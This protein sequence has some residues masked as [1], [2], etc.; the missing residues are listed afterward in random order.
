M[1]LRFQFTKYTIKSIILFDNIPVFSLSDVDECSYG[2]TICP[3]NSRCVN[4]IGS[5][6]CDCNVG[7]KSDENDGCTGSTIISFW[8]LEL[9]RLL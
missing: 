8:V 9:E 2:A 3:S 6:K 4:T 1:Q 7:L 5:F